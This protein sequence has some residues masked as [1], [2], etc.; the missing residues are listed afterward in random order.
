MAP[1]CRAPSRPPAASCSVRDYHFDLTRPGI[2]LYG[3][4]PFDAGQPVVTLSLPVIQTPRGR[5]G[6]DRWAMAAAGRPTRP[7]AIATVSRRLCR[8][9]LP[10]AVEHGRALAWRHALPAGRPRLDGPDHRRHHPSAT[11]CPQA[12]DIIGPIQ[13][14]DDLADIAGTIGYEVLT[15]S[16]PATPAATSGSAH[17]PAVPVARLGRAVLAALAGIGRVTL[18]AGQVV[19]TSCARPS[20]CANSAMRVLQ[21]GW[22]S[23]PVVG[24]TAIFTGGALALAD[25]FRRRALQRRGRRAQHRRHRHGARAW[26]RSWAA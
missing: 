9:A 11:R 25:L 13:T 19:A 16:R 5:P 18:F 10:D 7:R 17:E 2:G 1:A 12:L 26:A 24:L 3:G 15:A 8:R 6:R 14:V 22:F 23:L 21:I 20:T 4:L